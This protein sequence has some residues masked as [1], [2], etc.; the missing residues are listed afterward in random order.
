MRFSSKLT[1]MPLNWFK[2]ILSDFL[3]DV[4]S[5]MNVHISNFK[6]WRNSTANINYKRSVRSVADQAIKKQ[7]CLSEFWLKTLY[8]KLYCD[9][10]SGDN[11]LKVILLRR[12]SCAS[13]ESERSSV[14]SLSEVLHHQYHGEVCGGHQAT[15]R[16]ARGEVEMGQVISQVTSS[17]SAHN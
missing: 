9:V 12:Y 16:P 3:R 8:C 6:L 7:S 4:F 13:N 14:C 11:D 10:R 17:Q 2:E 1:E 15:G 5:G